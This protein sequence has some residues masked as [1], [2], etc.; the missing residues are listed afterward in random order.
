MKC[1]FCGAE[2]PTEAYLS[3]YT[4]TCAKCIRYC[5]QVCQKHNDGLLSW[6]KEP[7][8]SCENNPYRR[9]Y[10]W[11]GKWILKDSLTG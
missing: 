3:K 11:D 6:H 4:V 9:R 2:L 10:R 7:C 5:N 8:V 1:K